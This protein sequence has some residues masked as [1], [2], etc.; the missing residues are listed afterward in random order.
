MADT[1]DVVA[2]GPLIDSIPYTVDAKMPSVSPAGGDPAVARSNVSDTGNVGGSTPSRPSRGLSTDDKIKCEQIVASKLMSPAQA[3]A[4]HSQG[5]VVIGSEPAPATSATTSRGYRQRGSTKEENLQFE[6]RIDAARTAITSSKH[7]PAPHVVVDTSRGE[8]LDSTDPSPRTRRVK[9]MSPKEVEEALAKQPVVSP[10]DILSKHKTGHWS[11][12]TKLHADVATLQPSET[13]LA[14]SA[15]HECGLALST[16][17]GSRVMPST[18]KTLRSEGEMP[19]FKVALNQALPGTTAEAIRRRVMGT[20]LAIAT[21]D[22]AASFP[23]S[24][25][26]PSLISRCSPELE[27]CCSRSPLAFGMSWGARSPGL[28]NPCLQGL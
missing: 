8:K 15:S 18:K 22:H 5:S 12:P 1:Q 27:V 4:K 14:M 13:H 16:A 20:S 21:T 25:K 7:R 26:S 10:A 23:A 11:G 9:G 19:E 17:I 24:A 3:R 6:A 2:V 28:M